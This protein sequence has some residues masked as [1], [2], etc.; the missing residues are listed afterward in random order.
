[1]HRRSKGFVG[2]ILMGLKAQIM[3]E[4]VQVRVTLGRG[5]REDFWL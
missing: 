5:A 3:A 1:M 4:L 2:S